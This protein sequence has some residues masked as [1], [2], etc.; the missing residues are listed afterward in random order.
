MLLKKLPLTLAIA[1]AG[2]IAYLLLPSSD[3]NL[4]GFR[5]F[6]SLHQVKID[7][8]GSRTYVP[9]D[10]QTG[11]Q[12][13]YYQ[14]QNVQKHLLF[15][16]YA[17]FAYR[18]ARSLGYKGSGLKPLQVANAVCAAVTLGL[19]ALLLSLGME[20]IWSVIFLT[21]GLALSNAFGSMATNIGEVVFALPLLIIGLILI[22]K[23]KPLL[24]GLALGI[25]AACYLAS[26]VIALTVVIGFII[27]HQIKNAFTLFI[28]SLTTVSGC[29][30]GLLFCAGYNS[31]PQLL[32]TL[33]LLP[34][35]GTF[36]GFKPA[37]L[38]SV[39]IGF[40]NSILPLLPQ[41]F[42]GLRAVVTS[43]GAR[44][45]PA[46]I[47]ALSAMA[48]G[49]CCLLFNLRL[50]RRRDEIPLGLLVFLG[51]LFTSLLWDP[52]HLKIWVYSNIGLWLMLSEARLISLWLVPKA[53]PWPK[54]VINQRVNPFLQTRFV[55]LAFLFFL[56]T[57]VVLINIR[58]L[59][60]LTGF[61]PRWQAAAEISRIVA[62]PSGIENKN[63]IFGAWEPE[64]G[65]LTLFLPERNLICLPDLI[66]ENNI[67][68]RAVETQIEDAI[69]GCRNQ[70]GLVYFVNLFNRSEE[71]LRL[72]YSVRLHFP[73]LLI[74]VQT[75]RPL[76]LIV[77]QDEKMAIALFRLK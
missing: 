62:Q 23:G 24:A 40:A 34:E 31:F 52:Y 22:I 10:W 15:P 48:L 57:P 69:T 39:F 2:L 17:F 46:V 20:D 11:Y 27:R 67:D 14:R 18:L 6:A 28:T 16:V 77:W 54:P 8:T 53:L 74:W 5:V 3:Y 55:P 56:L 12:K 73:H 30:L 47:I 9:L 66:L 45:I 72:F 33:I 36:G 70:G 38:I 65:Y 21:I 58:H 19:F 13:P 71:Q 41:D 1:L 43:G 49:L 4:D 51:A 64:F 42:S 61:N 60:S 7:S 63:L 50:F 32:N 35:Q 29:Y 37:N 59:F 68:P 26:I 75:H 76:V 25:S 44:L